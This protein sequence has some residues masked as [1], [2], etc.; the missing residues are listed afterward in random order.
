MCGIVGLTVTSAA[1]RLAAVDAVRRMASTIVH[2]GPDDEGLHAD[3]HVVLAMRRLSIIDLSG[4]HQPICNEDETLWVVCNGEIY[5]FQSVRADLQRRGHRFRTGSDVEVLLH[6]YEEHGDRFLDHVSGMFAVALW[7]SRRRRL[8]L[9]RDRLGIK[10][11]YYTVV[12]GQLAFGSEI[13]TLLSLPQVRRGVDRNALRE[14]LTLGYCVAPNTIFEG[15]RKLPPATQ[16]VWSG[17]G[18]IKLETYWSPPDRI[19]Q[20]LSESDW[21][22]LMRTELKRAVSEHMIADVPIG[23]FLSGGIDSSAVVALMGESSGAPVNTYSIGYGGGGVAEY[24]NELSYAGEVARSFGTKHN[25]ILVKPDVA[26][27]LPKLMWHLEE[28][29]SDSAI[30]T[31]YLVSELA[32]KHVKV[33]LS[34]VG[35]DELFAGYRRYLGDHY[36]RRYH[37]LPEWLR[38]QV[39]QPIA[40]ALPSGRQSRMAD[41][42]RYAKKFVRAS[43]LPW[44]EQYREF[45][46]IQTRDRLAALL[47]NAPTAPDGFDLITAGESSD[48]PLLRLMRVDVRTQLAEDL[49][50]LTDKLTMACSIECRVPFL[51]HRLV[52]AA[53]RIPARH[54]LRNGEL[55]HVLKRSL[56][57]V[58]PDSVLYR[59]KRGFGAPVGAWFKSELRPLRNAVLSEAAIERRGMLNWPAVNAIVQAHDAGHEDYTDLILVLINLEIWNR[60]FLDGE[61]PADVGEAL[62]ERTLAA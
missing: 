47:A 42:A 16:L 17:S 50:L 3:D 62:A 8:I 5:N 43:E 52:E 15:I 61:S 24:Y 7:D 4:G 36:V 25:E 49:L 6:L 58:L 56:A 27:L 1:S 55:K 23:A 11:L 30:T 28:P 41:L 35:G 34:G 10:P 14:Y 48:D 51:D 59:E 19:D 9:A 54:K 21:I 12:D 18:D 46:E 26:A 53:A 37:K 40:A 44:R 60:V 29:V 45:I 57:G 38:R 20:T 39:L 22:E 33:I 32:A 31:T 13:K 2:R